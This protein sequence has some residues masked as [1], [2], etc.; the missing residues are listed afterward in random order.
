M[1]VQ[2]PDLVADANRTDR[3]TISIMKNSGTRNPKA[4]PASTAKP[5]LICVPYLEPRD[6]LHWKKQNSLEKAASI[7]L[8]YSAK[9]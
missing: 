4:T 8:G 1:P 3:E 2:D 6:Y 9:M 7:W 5:L